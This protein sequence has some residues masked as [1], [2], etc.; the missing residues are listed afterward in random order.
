MYEDTKTKTEDLLKE[1]RKYT[2]IIS[3][4]E[5]ENIESQDRIN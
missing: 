3:K 5:N 1:I 4:K 2:D